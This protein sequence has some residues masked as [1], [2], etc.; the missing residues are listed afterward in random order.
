MSDDIDNYIPY[1]EEVAS[2]ANIVLELGVGKGTGS[3]LAFTRALNRNSSSSIR[4][5]SVDHKDYMEMKPTSSKWN[6]VIGDSR[7]ISTYQTVKLII[8][9]RYVDIIFI[10]TDHTPCQVL[11][12]LEL[13][14]KLADDH[15]IWLFHDT[16]MM[17]EYNPMV[18]A[19]KEF[20]SKHDW[21]YE[22]VFTDPHGLGKM[23]R[24]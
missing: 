22:D 3:T 24:P 19:I 17:G 18:D 20:A 2:K 8:G 14:S 16:Y 12:E 9:N 23:Y 6:L 7:A 13:W 15:T 11:A 4:L 10:D 21:V 1:L 5:I